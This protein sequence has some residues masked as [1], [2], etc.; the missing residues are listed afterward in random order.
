MSEPEVRAKEKPDG[1][2][3]SWLGRHFDTSEN[4]RKTTVKIGWICIGLASFLLCC[5]LVDVF[6]LHP[7]A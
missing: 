3:R 1:D 6:I 5:L 4:A 2:S 7:R